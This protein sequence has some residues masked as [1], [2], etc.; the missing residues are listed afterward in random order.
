MKRF[1][2][3][4]I[5][6]LTAVTLLTCVE[7]ARA[8]Q[9]ALGD[10]FVLT[11]IAADPGSPEGLV[12]HGHTVFVSTPARFGNAGSGPS[13]VYA[14]DVRSGEQLNEYVIQGEDL[15]QD[16]GLSG[17]AFDADDRLYV[18]STQLGI[19][20]IDVVSGQQEAYSTPFPPLGPPPLP[21]DIAFDDAGNAY[22]TDSLVGLIWR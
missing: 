13:K 1:V 11:P 6:A 8:D 10:T 12:V 20:R 3:G 19:L 14:F 17:L 4:Y 2:I 21:N 15:S 22:V 5:V 9:R 18:L 7:L 16:H